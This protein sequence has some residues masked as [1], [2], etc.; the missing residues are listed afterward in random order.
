[1][2]VTLDLPDYDGNAV[3]VI[4][5]NG[6]KYVLK[7]FDNTVTL[8]GNKEGFISLAKQLLYFAHND[9]MNGDH[10]HLDGFFTKMEDIKYELVIEKSNI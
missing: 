3:D 9:L 7:V 1:M 8:S 4:W 2:K 10:V 6:A 5:E